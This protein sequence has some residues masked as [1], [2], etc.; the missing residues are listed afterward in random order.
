VAGCSRAGG[1]RRSGASVLP[2]PLRCDADEQCDGICTFAIRVCGEVACS[3]HLVSVPVG[4]RQKITLSTTLGAAPT[5]FVLRCWSHPPTIPCPV[6]STST[7]TVTTTTTTLPGTACQS[8]PDC[9]PDGNPCILG[10]CAAGVCEQFCRCLQGESFTCLPEQADTCQSVADC[11]PPL[12]G[13]PCRFCIGGLC[14][15]HPFCV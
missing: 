8:D 11:A 10:F 6:P 1:V 7:T 14:M 13:D 12:L 5:T 3:E 2:R 15:G 4:Q 9:N